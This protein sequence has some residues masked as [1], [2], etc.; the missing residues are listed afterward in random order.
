MEVA[1]ASGPITEARGDAVVAEA[2]ADS[3][4]PGAI[5]RL[6]A[7]TQTISDEPLFKDNAV[8]LLVDGPDTYAA[9]LAA[10]A[11]AKNHINLETY[12]FNE[13]EV[14]ERFADALM[15][16]S[17]EGVEVRLIYDSIGSG[18]SSDGF[19]ERMKAAGIGVVEFHPVNPLTGGNPMDLN[20][21]DHRKLLIVDGEVAFTGGINLDRNYASSSVSRR[22]TRPAKPAGW[23]DTHIEVRGPAVAGFQRLFL[24][25]WEEG[26]GQRDEGEDRFFPKLEAHG[27][28]LVRVLSAVG[29]DGKVSSIRSAYGYAMEAAA[30][31]I[32]I[33][34]SYFGPDPDF[35][36]T[37]IEAAARGV[38]VR[39]IVTGFSDA[40][41]LLHISRS[42]YGDLLR[43]GVHVYESSQIMLHAVVIG[44]DF[45]GAMEKLFITDMARSNEITL[46][47]WKRRPWLDRFKEFFSRLGQY[48]L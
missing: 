46:E 6:V 33:T 27:R 19:F 37:M 1:G 21:R 41:M 26:G 43:A 35:L 47:A 10:I 25:N 18:P 44:E 16:K 31:R 39:I 42:C 48:W 14:G 24:E 4:D 20:V 30:S 34:Q 9:M 15:R 36:D 5:E 7:L 29:G 32:W 3:R 38:D 12:I 17:R 22:R 28:D 8:R 23:R 13:D 11:A 2:V 45:G 40:P